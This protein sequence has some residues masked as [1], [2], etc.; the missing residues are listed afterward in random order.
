MNAGRLNNRLEILAALGNQFG[1]TALGFVWVD[2][3]LTSS[4]GEQAGLRSPAQTEMQARPAPGL[5]SGQFL[6]RGDQLWVIDAV[7]DDRR[8]CRIMATELV[9]ETATYVPAV[10]DSYA[11][12]V[13]IALNAPYVDSSGVGSYRHRMDLAKVELAAQPV[14]GDTIQARSTTWSVTGMA[15]G[16][17]DGAVITLLV[18]K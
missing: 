1:E 10:G 4:G 6:R 11:V 13:F 9:G 3:R 8:K 17:D 7:I 16:G 12:R 15:D 14:K 2:I 18:R 5:T